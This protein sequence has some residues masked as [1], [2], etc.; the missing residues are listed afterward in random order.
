MS[1]RVRFEGGAELARAL[2]Q[3]STRVSKKFVKEA[4]VHA[5]EPLRDRME[6]LAPHEPGKPDLRD[7]LAVSTARG[8]DR[9]ETAVAIG[10]TKQG[11]Y[12]SFLELGTATMAA[13]PFVRPALDEKS[14]E[15]LQRLSDDLWVSLASRG[16]SRSVSSDEDTPVESGGGTG[17]L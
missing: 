17:L 2:S 10:P 12:G 9:L 6:E 4:L 1:F 8:E 7:T 11:F 3:L 5:A 14:S 16:I 15:A 13:Q